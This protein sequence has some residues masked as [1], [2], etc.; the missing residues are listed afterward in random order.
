MK[1]L[2]AAAALFCT[3]LGS[4]LVSL[5]IAALIFNGGSP[6]DGIAIM[7][8]SGL[9]LIAGLVIGL[10]WALNIAVNGKPANQIEPPLEPSD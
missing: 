10:I 4:L 8:V 2:K 5:V 6:G 9:G 3:L 1:W 7:G